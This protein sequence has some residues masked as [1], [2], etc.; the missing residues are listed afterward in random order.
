MR[1][2]GVLD[3]MA[4]RGHHS[5]PRTDFVDGFIFVQMPGMDSVEH[6]TA[7]TI[8]LRIKQVL[9]FGLLASARPYDRRA[10]VERDAAAAY[11]RLR[12]ETTRA[13]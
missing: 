5:G 12:D 10:P 6:L 11:S 7:H 1:G 9:A 2:G 13:A 8:N 3:D 4:G